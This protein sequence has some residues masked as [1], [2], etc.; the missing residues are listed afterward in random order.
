MAPAKFELLKSRDFG[1]IITDTFVFIRMNFKPL[2]ITI[3][4]FCGFFIVA[5]AILSAIQQAK[6]AG[7][8]NEFASSAE[9]PRL[10]SNSNPF[11][12][13]FNVE[14]FL[15]IIFV[16]LNYIALPVAV[17]SFIA[18]YREKDGVAPTPQE[19]W[20]Y[21]KYFFFRILGSGIL[22]ALLLM[23]GFVLCI[24]PGIYLYPIFAMVFPV[25]V[26]ENASFSYAFSKSFRLIKDKWWE[27]FGALFVISLIVGTAAAIVAIPTTIVNFGS[28]ILHP[29]AGMHLSVTLSVITAVL[30][31]ICQLLYVVPFVTV[32]LCYFNLSEKA[33]NTGLLG[34][35]SQLGQTNAN[36]HLPKEEY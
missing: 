19:V 15:T 27:T 12:R 1:E 3:I 9:A 11:E 32:A 2:L 18:L 22:L 8:M 33:E 31:S 4:T 16:M 26:F 35:I 17:F 34:R 6:T 23:I 29:K 10:F 5:T 20:G 13:I 21:F 30:Q 7:I 25:M 24:I 36:D 14:Y 28:L